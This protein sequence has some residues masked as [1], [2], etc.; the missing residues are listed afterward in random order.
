MGKNSVKE[1]KIDWRL[2]KNEQKSEIFQKNLENHEFGS[3]NSINTIF[4]EKLQFSSHKKLVW[5][6]LSPMTSIF[7]I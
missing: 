7:K 4:L 1:S 6:V 2:T 5:H 3:I